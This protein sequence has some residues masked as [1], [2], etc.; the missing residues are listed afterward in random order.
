MLREL[1]SCIKAGSFKYL[2]SHVGNCEIPEILYVVFEQPMQCLKIRLLAS[3]S[4]EN[5]PHD[6][7]LK[8][9]SCIA[10]ALRH[11]SSLKIMHNC[12]CAR[13]IGLNNDW[14]PKLMGHGELNLKLKLKIFS[15]KK[16]LNKVFNI[17]L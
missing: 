7:I 16:F 6:Q 5:F 17:F 4:G 12:I 13:S 3:R 15:K 14:T 2:A 1:D 11:L 10:G 8:I 9:G